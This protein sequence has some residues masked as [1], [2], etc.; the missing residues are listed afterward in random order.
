MSTEEDFWRDL[1]IR[2]TGKRPAL[3]QEPP[4]VVLL[5]SPE[6]DDEV[7]DS[8]LL[9]A[10]DGCLWLLA[11]ECGDAKLGVL[12]EPTTS[13]VGYRAFFDSNG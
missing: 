9:F 2:F 11:E 4:A 3:G 12:L 6:D 13:V 1:G 7:D 10:G 5:H 8:A